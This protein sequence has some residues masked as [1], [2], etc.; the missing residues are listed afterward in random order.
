[1]VNCAQIY[2]CL[3][4]QDYS[5]LWNICNKSFIAF[6]SSYV[7]EPKEINYLK[8]VHLLK[9]T[10]FYLV[11]KEQ[12]DRQSNR[13]LKHNFLLQCIIKGMDEYYIMKKV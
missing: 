12:I 3:C 2:N 7:D 4:T 9:L 1:M 8:C 5:F 6:R 10:I 11:L 13:Q